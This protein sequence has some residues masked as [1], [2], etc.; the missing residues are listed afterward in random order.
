MINWKNNEGISCRV[1]D[2]NTENVE[3]LY[4]LFEATYGVKVNKALWEWKYL[5]NPRN[6][7]I[8]IF[9]AEDNGRVVAATTR[10]PAE[11]KI[12]ENIY[13]VY[14]SVDSVVHP[15]YRRR[16]IMMNLYKTAAETMPIMLSKGTNPEMYLLLKKMGY[17][18]IIP[19]T[20]MVKYLSLPKLVMKKLRIYKPKI[21]LSYASVDLDAG[22]SHVEKFGC[23]F[24]NFFR[25]VS[26]HYDGILLKDSA[27]MN[28]RYKKIPHRSYQTFYRTVD[29]RI[30]STV[31]LMVDKTSGSIVDIIWDKKEKDE[32]SK[33]IKF[34]INFFKKMGLLKI[35][36]WGTLSSLRAC[37]EGNGFS[38]EKRTPHF[39]VYTAPTLIDQLADG[40]EIHFISGDGD[41]EYL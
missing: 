39:S 33:T 41:S 19:N 13:R 34:A 10:L 32:P 29:D 36:F 24:D 11:L 18:D 31:I 8:K 17:K 25:R 30:I 23:E 3:H 26:R 4:D 37:C 7:E 20:Y 16:G 21:L 1:F 15:E 22:F 38:D 2:F 12:G 35:S 27:Y 9:V 14:F 5:L 28:W 6:E 40:R